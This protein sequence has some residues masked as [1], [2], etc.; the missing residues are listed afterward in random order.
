MEQLKEQLLNNTL[1]AIDYD[2][3]GTEFLIIYIS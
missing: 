2:A 3:T 1:D